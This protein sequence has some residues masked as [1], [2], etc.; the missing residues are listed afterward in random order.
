MEHDVALLKNILTRELEIHTRLVKTAQEMNAA[1][2]TK[3]LTT[4]QELATEYDL[5]AVQIEELEEKRIE[6]CG[7]IATGM[8]RKP[9]VITMDQI[10]ARLQETEKNE[11][12]RIRKDLKEMIRV[13]S[14]QTRSN[15]ILLEETLR[16][17]AMEFKIYDSAQNRFSGYK[18]SG[19]MRTD[20]VRR[21][22]FSQKA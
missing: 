18:L 3:N 5:Y 10:L 12:G 20:G 8:D 17:I 7:A 6:V 2:K 9:A 15:Q 11:L 22:L 4:I 19:K 14:Q 1:I 16:R 13:L 21:P